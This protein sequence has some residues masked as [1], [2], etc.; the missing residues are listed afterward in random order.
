MSGYRSDA[1]A[2]M[3]GCEDDAVV[4]EKPFTAEQLAN[5]VAESLV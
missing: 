1:A 3:G 5:A 4:L 2:T